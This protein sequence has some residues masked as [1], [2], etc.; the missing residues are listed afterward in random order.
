VIERLKTEI[1]DRFKIKDLGE[2][3]WILK[4]QV[5]RTEDGIWIGQPSYVT[6]ILKDTNNWDIPESK[7]KDAPMSVGW[8]HDD[9]SPE[10]SE[11]DAT[12]FV[13]ITAKLLY[14]ATQTR[15]DIAFAVNTVSQYQ[16]APPRVNDMVEVVRIL[17]YLRKTYDLGLFFPKGSS[18]KVVI[19][20]TVEETVDAMKRLELPEGSQM[21]LYTDASYGEDVN[22]K[23]RSG[24]M[25]CVFGAPV[26]WYSKKQTTT[27][28]S[29]T[30]AEAN[31]LT[32]GIKESI[33]M[34]GF[35]DEVGFNGNDP[36]TAQQ[37]NQSVIALAVNPIHHGRVKHMEIK[38]HFI[39]ENVENSTIKLVYCP[40]ELM[41]ADILTKA[42]PA[43]VHNKFVGMMG[44]RKLGDFMAGRSD[45]LSLQATLTESD[46]RNH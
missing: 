11:G 6:Q 32:E 38:L 29:S 41:I 31:S 4:I 39:R 22:R 15:P 5:E 45:K 33:W 40:T 37:D 12:K 30:E 14:L 16:R 3:K 9:T 42:L 24:Y 26:I 43:K 10:L 28:M 7:W 27:A 13:G 46:K 36:V 34:K 25:F 1:R 18:D 19:Y 2:A 17:R 35:L 44:M 21:E 20:E 8:E 23:S